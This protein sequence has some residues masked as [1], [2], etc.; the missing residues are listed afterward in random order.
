MFSKGIKVEWDYSQEYIEIDTNHPSEITRT[1]EWWPQDKEWV[2]YLT[3]SKLQ[4]NPDGSLLLTVYY[5][6]DRNPDLQ[7]RDVPWGYSQITIK[8]GQRSGTATWLDDREDERNGEA[9]WFLFDNPL[10]GERKRERVSRIS[11]EQQQYRAALVFLDAECAITKE[12]TIEALEAAHI[13]P[14]KLGGSEIV[15]NGIL[16]RADI[17]RLFD[18]GCFSIS[19]EGEVTL[20]KDLSK[21]YRTLLAGKS[22]PP[23]VVER[24]REALKYMCKSSKA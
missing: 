11:R 20:K 9:K 19:S 2:E 15:Q 1:M 14:V 16:L 3:Y 21:A 12:R 18:A 4:T 8:P 6:K 10:I 5:K 23:Q 22:L 7:Y 13:V 17:H 24:V